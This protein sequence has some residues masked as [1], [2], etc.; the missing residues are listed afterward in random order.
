MFGATFSK[1]HNSHTQANYQF[2]SDELRVLRECD[3]ESFVQRS[4][5]LGTTFGLA[6]YMAVK[7]GYLK[8]SVR[9]GAV[10][11]VAI[12][13]IVGYFMGKFSYQ[14]QCAEKIMRL[15]D[16]KLAEMLRMRRR[17]GGA[18][19]SFS[20]DHGYGAAL[21]MSPF[22]SATDQYSDV[23]SKVGNTFLLYSDNTRC[24][25]CI[26]FLFPVLVAK[27]GHGATE[28]L[29]AGRRLSTERRRT[30]DHLR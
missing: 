26:R 24:L 27:S 9:F 18:V 22:A 5:P 7:N 11:K 6:A 14:N 10:P 4:V 23:T 2:S 17:G 1:S 19:D 16:S 3:V 29:R 13:V 25:T 30:Y 8:G 20:V 21:S 12:G 15:P 28:Q